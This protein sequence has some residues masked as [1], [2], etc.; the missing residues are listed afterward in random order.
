MGGRY[1]AINSP[2]GPRWGQP[3]TSWWINCAIPTAH[4][5]L[6]YKIM[7]G[8]ILKYDT[9][10]HRELKKDDILQTTAS[11]TFSFVQISSSQFQC[12][13]FHSHPWIQIGVIIR[14][15]SNRRRIVAFPV[16]VTLLFD[17]WHWKT[18]GHLFYATS[19]SV[20]HIV[21]ICEFKLEFHSGNSQFR[22]K[23]SIFRPV[24]PYNFTDYLKKTIRL[25]F[26]TPLQILWPFRSHLWIQTGVSSTETLNLGQGRRFFGALHLEI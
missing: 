4:V 18:I 22:S 15:R 16:L 2:L 1:C 24:W 10:T 17:G 20:H 23:S 5:V 19:I 26:F 3:W 12:M 11:N 21:A 8:H 13:S 9:Q 7:A 6:L 25:L 14:K